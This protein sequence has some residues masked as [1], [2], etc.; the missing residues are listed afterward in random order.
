MLEMDLI[1][2]SAT[3]TAYCSD[4]GCD[5]QRSIEVYVD[6]V[7]RWEDLASWWKELEAQGWRHMRHRRD[8]GYSYAVFCPRCK[9]H[10]GMRW[11]KSLPYWPELIP[12]GVSV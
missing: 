4:A 3:V 2:V 5:A 6:P 12:I 11:R 10:D 7:R 9:P 8:Y 1:H